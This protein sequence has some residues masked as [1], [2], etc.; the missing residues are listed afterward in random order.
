MFNE[1]LGPLKIKRLLDRWG[2]FISES[3]CMITHLQ[4]GTKSYFLINVVLNYCISEILH[5][6]V[7]KDH[8][9]FCITQNGND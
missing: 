9:L 7:I 3:V 5:P 6:S 4:K 8:Y 1:C 2:I